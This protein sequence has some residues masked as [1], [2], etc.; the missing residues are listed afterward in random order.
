MAAEKIPLFHPSLSFSLTCWWHTHA[1]LH[2]CRYL[3]MTLSCWLLWT[4]C[5]AWQ[6]IDQSWVCLSLCVSAVL[7]LS[8]HVPKAAKSRF[9]CRAQRGHTE[10]QNHLHTPCS[11]LHSRQILKFSLPPLF[12]RKACT[13]IKHHTTQVPLQ[14]T[15]TPLLSVESQ[16]RCISPLFIPSCSHFILVLYLWDQKANGQQFQGWLHVFVECVVG[17]ICT[18]KWGKPDKTSICGRPHL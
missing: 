17:Q 16:N 18:Q 5:P 11:L 8:H 2:N 10:G 9:S 13:H 7:P 1:V 12:T 14:R 4:C 15:M 3:W 6:I